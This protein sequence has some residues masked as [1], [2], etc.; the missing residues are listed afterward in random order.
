[1]GTILQ[2]QYEMKLEFSSEATN[3]RFSLKCLPVSDE[4][5]QLEECRLEIVPSCK[6]S[7]SVDSFCNH[8]LY[9]VIEQPH[10]SFQVRLTGIIQ[11]SLARGRYMD[12]NT[13]GTYRY[14]SELT[15]TGRALRAF[16]QEHK[17]ADDSDPLKVA[18]YYTALLYEKMQYAPGTTGVGTTAEEAMEKGCGVCQDYAHIMIALLRMHHIP[19]RYVVGLMCGEGASHAWVEA[20]ADGMWY[21]FDPTNGKRVDDTYLHISFGRDANDCQINRGVFVGGGSQTQSVHA[22]VSVVSGA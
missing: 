6:Y 9:G 4:L 20:G 17:I 21:G 5:Q 1:M 18:D 3:H 8:V 19:A 13:I 7:Y 15:R 14:P 12:K 10:Q 16:W 22:I 11:S 2:F